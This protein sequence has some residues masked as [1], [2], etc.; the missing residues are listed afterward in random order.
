MENS[1]RKSFDNLLSVFVCTQHWLNRLTYIDRPG[2]KA[3]AK[4][5]NCMQCTG[6]Y[7]IQEQNVIF[8]IIML[9]GTVFQNLEFNWFLV[10]RFSI[11]SKS[12]NVF[13]PQCHGVAFV[14]K[15]LRKD[16]CLLMKPLINY[17]H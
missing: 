15:I 13:L 2:Y 7:S 8:L 11:F 5:T 6:L 1:A 14:C 3:S 17:M 12:A 4:S 9:S 16:I 10:S